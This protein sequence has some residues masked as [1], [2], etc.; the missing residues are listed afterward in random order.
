M[1][2]KF[3]LASKLKPLLGTGRGQIFIE[4]LENCYDPIYP[5]PS[6]VFNFWE[7]CKCSTQE[8]IDRLIPTYPQSELQ[9][10]LRNRKI[11]VEVL[12]VDSWDYWT[13]SVHVEDCFA[14][15]CKV[16]P[17]KGE[18]LEFPTYE[19]ALEAGLTKALDFI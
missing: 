5:E 4:E 8:R 17:E 7:E 16:A 10:F 13:Y 2:I 3:E 18:F 1:L 12:P 14:P 15:F 9:T 6:C 11:L 19:D